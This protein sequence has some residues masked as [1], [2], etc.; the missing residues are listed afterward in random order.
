[1]LDHNWERVEDDSPDRCQ[2]MNATGQCQIKSQ[3]DSDYCPAHSNQKSVKANRKERINQYQIQ[4][5][6][7]KLS[8]F[9]NHDELKTVRA[10]IAMLRIL[11]ETHWNSCNS[12]TA[13]MMKSQVIGDL[14]L[15]IEKLVTSCVKLDSRIGSTLDSIQAIQFAQEII[16]IIGNHIPDPLTLENIATEILE[17]LDGKANKLIE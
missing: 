12:E 14:I 9:E 7:E 17:S 5:F 8:R 13:L 1:M 16:T 11:M 6:K 3:E 2:A 4:L 10:E 15:K